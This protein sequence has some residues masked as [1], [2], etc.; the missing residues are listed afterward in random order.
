MK[1]GCAAQ[2]VIVAKALAKI[3]ATAKAVVAAKA[4]LAAL[5]FCLAALFSCQSF[6]ASAEEY[7]AIG[8]AYFEIGK[9]GEAE[10]W[11]FRARSAGRTRVA[12]D[13]NLGRIAYETGRYQD[14]AEYFETVLDLDPD[15]VMALRALA[16]TRIKTGEIETAEALYARVLE[17]V[18]DNA[19][20]GYNHALV[21]YAM[22]KY[23]AAEELILS[24]YHALESS[25]DMLLLFARTQ[26]AL[27]KV[28][29]VDSY[30]QWL[31]DNSDNRVRYEYAQVLEGAELY[32][33]ALEEYQ[34]ALTDLPP[35]STDPGAAEI[36]FS[37]ARVYLAADAGNPQGMTE[38]KAAVEGGF[39]D[40]EALKALALDERIGEADRAEIQKL[41]E[42]LP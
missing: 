2:A 36:R 22:E 17:L 13:Y 41:T 24:R 34:A 30:A 23:D 3:A 7:Y 19:D 29:A 33:R 18:P 42:N 9:Y 28:E 32:A 14:A 26:R 6:G 21:L 12:S 8:M 38:L 39:A 11:L 4:A 25:K 15:N 16:Y 1:R 27:G 37:L 5:V 10:R 35:D 20:D 40:R 31:K